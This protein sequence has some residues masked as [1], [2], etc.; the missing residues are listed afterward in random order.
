MCIVSRSIR[1]RTKTLGFVPKFLSQTQASDLA[2]FKQDLK[3][4]KEVVVLSGAG[5]SAESGIPTFRG[6]DGL[7]RKL[8]CPDLSKPS[9]FRD[10]PG[11]VWEFYHFRREMVLK[12]KPNAGHIAIAQYE[13]RHKND[14]KV[15]VVT[16]NFD[17]LHAKAGS[18]RVIELHGNLFKTRC[19][20]CNEVLVNTDSPICPALAGQGSPTSNK[21]TSDIAEKDLPHCKKPDCNGLL[22]PHIVWFGETLEPAIVEQTDAVISKCNVCL[23]VGTS[24]LVF[25]AAAY[26]SVMAAGGTIVAEF[27]LEPTL[28]SSTKFDYYFE[29]PSSVTLPEA[30]NE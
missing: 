1:K 17:G 21:L 6:N 19:T 16:Q 18:S 7:W 25:P 20:K 13:A 8:S 4:A 10:D 15:T 22:R 23:V 30:L 14:K 3:S 12:T 2:K 5:I 27:N 9:V 29:G 11:L 28:I 26:P 24:S